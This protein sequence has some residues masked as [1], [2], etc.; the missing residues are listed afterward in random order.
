MGCHGY[1]SFL[2]V[3]NQVK[4]SILTG[5]KTDFHQLNQKT[6]DVRPKTGMSRFVSFKAYQI[7]SH[8]FT[9]LYSKK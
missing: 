2:F 8:T 6:V 3:F 7:Y 5:N 4:N 1:N 9:K